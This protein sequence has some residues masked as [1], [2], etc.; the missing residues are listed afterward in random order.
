MQLTTPGSP[1][2]G[3]GMESAAQ[4][5]QPLLGGEQLDLSDWIVQ[6]PWNFEKYSSLPLTTLLLFIH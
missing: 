2:P 5:F 1:I 6:P 4:S 3:M